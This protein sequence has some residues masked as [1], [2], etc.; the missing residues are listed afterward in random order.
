MADNR[1]SVV[2]VAI[3]AI[4]AAIAAV[5]ASGAVP[6]GIALPALALVAVVFVLKPDLVEFREYERGVVFRFGKYDRTVGPGLVI[7]FPLVDKFVPVDLRTQTINI[8]SQDVTTLDNVKIKV[9]AIIYA[10]ISDPVAS[11]TQVKDYNQAIAFQV[12]AEIRDAVGKMA[13]EDVVTHADQI[14]SRV[15][16]SLAEICK[17]WGIQIIKV[18]LESIELPPSLV[19]A[20]RK[21]KEAHEYKVKVETEATAK[22]VSLGILDDAVSKMSDKTMAYLYLDA[23]KK[24][25][26]GKSNKIIFPLELS[27]LASL[28]SANMSGEN[29]PRQEHGGVKDVDLQK[30]AAAIG[31]SAPAGEKPDYESIA[32]KLI[33]A[34]SKKQAEVLDKQLEKPGG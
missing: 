28:L 24:I 16:A 17:K 10:K 27:R 12:H 5:V 6:L 31:F 33:E 34:Y 3:L 4:V 23:L 32:K 19:D 1:Q 26:D 14:N 29:V 7:I 25:A 15:Q 22:N 21:R 30:A 8:P 13:L 9:D 20:M 2:F 18:D 11:V